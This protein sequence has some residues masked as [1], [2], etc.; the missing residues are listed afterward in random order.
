VHFS[1]VELEIEWEVA[2]AELEVECEVASS[3]ERE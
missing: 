2:L 1:L 3:L